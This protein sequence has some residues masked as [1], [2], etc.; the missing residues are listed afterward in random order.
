MFFLVVCDKKRS[1]TTAVIHYRC[2]FVT[3]LAL[4]L[5]HQLFVK[6]KHPHRVQMAICGF[7]IKTQG[8]LS[9]E[10]L[11]PNPLAIALSSAYKI[12]LLVDSS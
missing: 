11:V 5:W 10:E 4:A 2:N 12:R 9:M 3:A 6:A 1:A 7:H 8:K